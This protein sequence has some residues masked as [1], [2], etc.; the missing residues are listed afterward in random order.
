VPLVD[1]HNDLPWVIRNDKHARGSV[2]DYGLDRVHQEGDTDIPRLREGRVSAQWWAAFIPT[3]TPGPARTVLEQIDIVR[4]MDER[5][6]D[7]LLRATRPSDIQKAKKTGKIAS[8][9]AIE[10][11]IGLEGSLGPLRAWHAAGARLMTLCHNETLSWVDSATDSPRSN[12]LSTFGRDVVLELNRLGMIVD[13]S[14]VAASAMHQVLDITRA[15]IVFSHSNAAALC[16]HRRNVP[17]DVL[18]RVAGNGGMVMASFIPSFLSPARH[19]WEK[20]FQ[21]S[22]GTIDIEDVYASRRTAAADAAPKATLQ[23][24]ADHIEYIVSRTGYDHVGIGSDFFGSPI[25]TPHGLENVSRYPYLFAE[26]IARGWSERHLTKLASGNFVRVFRKV[27][28][29]GRQLRKHEQP[30]VARAVDCDEDSKA[31]V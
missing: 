14:H 2:A 5:H 20:Q 8:F 29:V 21:N 11:G 18:D 17:D 12:G 7:I 15:P 24:V 4:Q 31:R 3:N 23:Q 28:Q 25:D 10:G 13:C 1:G 22:G 27:E 16:G 19:D 26:L 6:P 9:L 30:R